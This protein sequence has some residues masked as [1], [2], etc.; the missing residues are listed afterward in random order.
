MAYRSF[1]LLMS[2]DYKLPVHNFFYSCSEL[3]LQAEKE[4]AGIIT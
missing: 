3:G 2:W 1:D 4:L